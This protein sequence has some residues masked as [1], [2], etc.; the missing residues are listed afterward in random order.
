MIKPKVLVICGRNKKRSRTAESIYKNDDRI[1]IRSAGLSQSSPRKVSQTDLNWADYVLVM[2]HEQRK[3]IRDKFRASLPLN[4]AT[5]QIEDVY[6]YLDEALIKV[7]KQK[8]E[9]LIEAWIS[10]EA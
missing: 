1:E 5:L 9:P 10:N 4:M 2:D 8:M 3:H 7:L 6:E